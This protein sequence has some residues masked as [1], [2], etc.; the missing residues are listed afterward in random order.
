[1][2]HF[3]L[4]SF[5]FKFKNLLQAE[6]DATLT[7]KSEAGRASVTLSL[8]LGHVLSGQGQLPHR[9]RGGTARERRREKRAAARS[10]KEH[11]TTV[12]N[13]VQAEETTNAAEESSEA[14]DS[15][16][17][18][19]DFDAEEASAEVSPSLAIQKETFSCDICDFKSKWNN[20]LAI[21]MT[22]KHSNIEQL[23]GA[24]DTDN[25]NEAVVLEMGTKK[26]FE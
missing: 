23:D 10:E 2:A 20:G 16:N 21:H 14:V 15:D 24:A 25:E 26:S 17:A 19:R 13:Q 1:M 8:D 6:K 22:R 7:I 3:E 5:Y 4:D 9:S 12:T 11:A 18:N